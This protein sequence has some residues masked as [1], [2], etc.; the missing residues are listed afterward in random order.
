MQL[1]LSPRLRDIC[2]TLEQNPMAVLRADP[3]SG[4][5]TLIPLGL[6]AFRAETPAPSVPAKPPGKI[7]VLEPRRAAAAGIAGRMAELIGEAPGERVGYSVRMERKLSSETRIEVLTEGL[8]IRRIQNDPGLAGVSAVIL[9]EFHERSANTDLALAMLLDLRRLGSNI[10][11][12]VM[13]ATMDAP[14]VAE[15]MACA[16]PPGENS[17]PVIDVPGRTFPVEVYYRSLPGNISPGAACAA[18]LPAILEQAE[19][20]RDD[21]PSVLVFLPGKGEIETVRRSLSGQGL[22]GKYRVQIL[23]GS[24]PLGE[25]RAVVTGTGPG[26]IILATNVAET[27]ITV[28]GINL[29]VDSGLVRLERFHIPSGMNRL[30][31]EPA[32]LQSADQRAGRAG[33]VEPGT[34]VRL[35]RENDPRP[36]ETPCEIL[37]TGLS[38]LV[39][40]CCIWG[41][42]QPGDLPWLDPPPETAWAKALE[43]LA[44]LGAIDREFNPTPKGRRMVSLGLE[45]SLGVLCFS[46][47]EKNAPVLGAVLAALLSERDGAGL[48]EDADIRRRLELLR[49]EPETPWARGV[50]RLARD[51]LHRLGFTGH[52]RWTPAAEADSGEFLGRAF[53][54]RICRLQASGK[55]RFVSGREAAVS[56]GLNGEPWLVA[57]EVDAGER[58]GRIRLAAP[59]SEESALEVLGKYLSEDKELYWKGLKPRVRI[60]RRAGRI[61]LG[62]QERPAAQA[63]AAE[64]LSLLLIREGLGI[65]PWD[66]GNPPARNLLC[67]IRFY[68]SRPDLAMQDTWTDETLAAEAAQWLGPFFEAGGKNKTGPAVS[69]TILRDALLARLGWDRAAELGQGVPEY[70]TLPGGRKKRIDYCSGEPVVS[71]R[72]QD[73]F[74]LSGD[75]RIMGVPVLFRLLSPADR[76][77]Q[78]TNDLPGFWAGSY[79]DVR[80][81]MKGRYPKHHWPENPGTGE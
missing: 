26:R 6:M 32:S 28:P 31:L 16:A 23:H 60:T 72:V 48:R 4:K 22:S 65:L 20:D 57:A 35:W 38:S 71:M 70:F 36:K 1:P 29:V 54:G 10:G 33:R 75:T 78:I 80:K 59:L 37:R 42:R 21:L 45:P 12:L 47:A 15:F 13:S 61:S 30:C 63:E 25:Q 43:T 76:P 51:I 9:D 18:A 19:R 56:G 67:R 55:Y 69:G 73:A 5:S 27:G 62:E 64:G 24:L 58:S 52:V 50:Y 77:V 14:R 11:I 17:V 68:V 81:D 74:G 79:K 8:F 39:L 7:I 49:T 2:G 34:C 66:D 44:D 3:G 53:P 46:A 41:C 40:E